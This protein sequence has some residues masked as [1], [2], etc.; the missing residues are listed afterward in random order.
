MTAIIT[1]ARNTPKVAASQDC[2]LSKLRSAAINEPVHAPVPGRGMPTNRSNPQKDALR[3]FSL[4]LPVAFYTY[5][6]VLGRQFAAVNVSLFFLADFLYFWLESRFL[7]KEKPES[8]GEN[9][10]AVMVFFLWVFAFGLFSF[11][12]PELGIFQVPQ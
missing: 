1:E 11:F 4:F 7:R 5:S 12:P 2:F 9:V 10:L 3:I 8:E 6:G